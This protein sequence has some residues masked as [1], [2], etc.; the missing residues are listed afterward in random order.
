MVV[1][2]RSAGIVVELVESGDGGGE[3]LVDDSFWGMSLSLYP[4]DSGTAH[5]G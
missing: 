1:V 3:W 5:H 4:L 2:R